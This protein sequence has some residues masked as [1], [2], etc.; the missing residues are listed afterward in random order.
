MADLSRLELLGVPCS[1]KSYAVDSARSSRVRTRLAEKAKRPDR[2]LKAAATTLRRPAL[3]GLLATL[4]AVR[5]RHL[6]GQLRA[7]FRFVSR[8]GEYLADSRIRDGFLLVDEGVVQ[9]TWG[10]LLQPCLDGKL[11]DSEGWLDRISSR[12]WPSSDGGFAVLFLDT[13]R[14]EILRRAASRRANHPFTKIQ[15]EGDREAEEFGLE[16]L[17]R[18]RD[19]CAALGL[20]L[21]GDGGPPWMKSP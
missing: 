15:L 12:F 17:R 21:A 5:P 7:V 14:E 10:L 18:I 8:Y 2:L 19:R 9:A 6:G 11:R 1:G 13:P 16:L 20:L 4:G 3:L